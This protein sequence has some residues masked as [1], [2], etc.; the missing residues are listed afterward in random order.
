M[1]EILRDLIN[2][3]K[4]VSFIDDMMVGTES[5]EGHDDLVGGILKKIEENNLYM[6]LEKCR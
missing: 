4:I 1:S 6:K 5:K 3:G 2:T